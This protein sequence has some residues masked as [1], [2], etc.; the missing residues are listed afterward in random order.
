MATSAST[1]TIRMKSKNPNRFLVG[2]YIIV[3]LFR[4]CIRIFF[5]PFVPLL[6]VV[7]VETIYFAFFAVYF[8]FAFSPFP[9]RVCYSLLIFVTWWP[10]LCLCCV[11]HGVDSTAKGFSIWFS[12]Q[13]SLS[14]NSCTQSSVC[15]PRCHCS[16]YSR[17]DVF[18]LYIKMVYDCSRYI[19]IH[20]YI[21]AYIVWIVQNTF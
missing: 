9:S 19:Y 13:Q 20:I 15:T 2:I 18:A 1:K 4:I 6:L 8:S 14:A 5:R 12:T 7:A 10:L 11:H 17:L 16:Y 21:R 3:F